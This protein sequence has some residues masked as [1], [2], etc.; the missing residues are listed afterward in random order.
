MNE[1]NFSK[2]VIHWVDADIDNIRP[3]VAQ[4]LLHARELAVARAQQRHAASFGLSGN[5]LHRA[6]WFSNHRTAVVGVL[7]VMVLAAV[8]GIW[9][10]APKQQDDDVSQIDAALL[11][12]DLPVHAYLDNSFVQWIKNPSEQ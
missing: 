12:D 1:E 7:L 2:K 4:R 3:E 8:T 9:Q 6:S 11:T 5:A 10:V